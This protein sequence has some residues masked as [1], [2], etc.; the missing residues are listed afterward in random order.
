MRHEGDV[1]RDTMSRDV[2][3]KVRLQLSV[4]KVKLVFGVEDS[5]H[6]GHHKFG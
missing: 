2:D 6:D 5:Q 4:A 3:G 1:A